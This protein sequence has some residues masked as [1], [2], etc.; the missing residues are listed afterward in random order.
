LKKVISSSART[1]L[2]HEQL[3]LQLRNEIEQLKD[4]IWKYEKQSLDLQRQA[5]TVRDIEVCVLE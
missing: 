3:V 2:D 4:T 5:E 1:K